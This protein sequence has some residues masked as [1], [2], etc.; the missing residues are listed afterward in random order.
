MAEPII[1]ARVHP[2]DEHHC[3]GTIRKAQGQYGRFLGCSNAECQTAWDEHGWKFEGKRELVDHGNSGL[4]DQYVPARHPGDWEHHE[5]AVRT[6][7]GKG[8][9]TP[10]RKPD[11]VVDEIGVWEQLL[12]L[13]HG[14]SPRWAEWEMAS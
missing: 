10:E 12:G 8:D 7:G 9:F 5:I 13:V 1:A 2:G 4:P 3:G 14:E 6:G 11:V